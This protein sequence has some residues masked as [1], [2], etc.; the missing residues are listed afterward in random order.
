M[1]EQ[2]LTK[3]ELEESIRV[4]VPDGSVLSNKLQQLIWQVVQL[5]PSFFETDIEDK[6]DVSVISLSEAD[7]DE[8]DSAIKKQKKTE[9]WSTTYMLLTRQ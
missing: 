8:I 9:S 3:E 5:K 2:T 7:C 1:I 4:L 6:S